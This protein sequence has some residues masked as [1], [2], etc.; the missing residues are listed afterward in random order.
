MKDRFTCVFLPI[1]YTSFWFLIHYIVIGTAMLFYI[2]IIPPVYGFGHFLACKHKDH[3]ALS[4]DSI[5]VPLTLGLALI[6]GSIEIMVNMDPKLQ[7]LANLFTAFVFSFM[8]AH[9]I[10]YVSVYFYEKIKF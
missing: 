7:V 1:F 8:G 4:A 9:I 6:V 3:I 5:A 2:A 10:L